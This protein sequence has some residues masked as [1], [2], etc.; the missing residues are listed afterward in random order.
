MTESIMKSKAVSVFMIFWGISFVF[1]GA[2]EIANYFLVGWEGT[3]VI[4]IMLWLVVDVS[5]MLSGITL[6]A[7]AI[8]NLTAKR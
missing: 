8:K 4:E 6:W 7:I 1:Y 3:P 2:A 5:F